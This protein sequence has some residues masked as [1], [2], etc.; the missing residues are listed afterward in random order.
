MRATAAH[1]L[2]GDDRWAIS[3]PEAGRRLD[4]SRAHAY[5]LVA[6]GEL[7]SLR[8]GHRTV[9][10]VWALEAILT[11]LA[12][13][14]LMASGSGPVGPVDTSGASASGRLVRFSETDASDGEASRC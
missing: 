7:P 11:D 6:S 10:P 1:P 5:R 3:V 12:R 4:I 8:L 2:D 9:V 14:P 13:E